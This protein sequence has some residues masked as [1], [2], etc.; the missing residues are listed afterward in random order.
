MPVKIYFGVPGSG[1]TTHAAKIVYK[2][3]KKGIPTYSNVTIKGAIAFDTSMIG[4]IMIENCDLI[5]DEASIEYNNR[6]YKALPKEQINW[7]KLYRHYGVRNIY[8]YSQSYDDMDITLRRLSDVMYLVKKSIIPGLIVT[9]E[10][11]R[12]IG[13][14]QE[15]HQ[16][17]DQYFFGFLKMS[18]TIGR[19]YW[20][21][22]D[23]WDAPVLPV[24]KMSV[25]GYPNLPVSSATLRLIPRNLR[26]RKRK[27]NGKTND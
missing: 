11:S 1:K 22:F 6:N 25:I 16:I 21:M 27:R 3:L 24:R 4:K 7:F 13:I 23:S 9:R 20:K 12:K 26:I 14:N 8:I 18:F 2:N 5:I 19:K 15:S 17:E 10:I